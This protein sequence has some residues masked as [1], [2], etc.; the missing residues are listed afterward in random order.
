MVICDT[1]HNEAGIKQ[2]VEQL[3]SVSAEK[4]F[5]ILGVV[6]DKDLSKVLPLFPPGATYFFCE[7]S[8]PRALSASELAT[9]ASYYQLSG[10]VVPDV[11]AA[12]EKALSLASPKDLIFIGGSTFTVADLAGI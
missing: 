9:S 2:V 4:L 12:L 7:P 5:I 3:K 1:A 6:R 11:N 10:M 8:V